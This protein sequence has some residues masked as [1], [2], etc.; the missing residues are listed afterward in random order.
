MAMRVNAIG[1]RIAAQVCNT[2]L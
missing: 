1:I 2:R